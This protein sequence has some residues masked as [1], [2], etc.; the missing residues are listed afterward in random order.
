MGIVPDKFKLDAVDV[1][2]QARVDLYIL[3]DISPG[4]FPGDGYDGS[5]FVVDNDF[6]VGLARNERGREGVLQ[7][8]NGASDYFIR[9]S[10]ESDRRAVR[11]GFQVQGVLVADLLERFPV[12]GG[13]NVFGGRIA[14]CG[15]VILCN[16]L[17]GGKQ[18]MYRKGAEQ[19]RQDN[20]SHC[21]FG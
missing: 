7:L 17:C 2:K 18:R 6:Q 9:I 20:I 5:R 21:L 19:N 10:A 13:C 12:H 4:V 8:E 15:N 11:N 16:W 14:C 1:G 3:R